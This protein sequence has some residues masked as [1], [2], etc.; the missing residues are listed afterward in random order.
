MTPPKR[1]YAHAS[2]SHSARPQSSPDG[3]APKQ[4]RTSAYSGTA[5]GASQQDPVYIDDD[6]DDNNEEEDAS[7][8]QSFTE[9]EY[10]WMQYGSMRAN[11]VGIRYY[12]GYATVGERVVL[13]RE[14]NNAYDGN[15]P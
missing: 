15:E 9:Q 13:R 1:S 6:D 2:S 11:I 4:P 10:N 5:P 8:T 3:R 14:P 12:H 7:A